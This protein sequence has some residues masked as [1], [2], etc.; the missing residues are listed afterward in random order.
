MSKTLAPCWRFLSCSVC[1]PIL[2]FWNMFALCFPVFSTFDHAFSECL[3]MS[4]AGILKYK[5]LPESVFA[6]VL[7]WFL[8]FVLVPTSWLSLFCSWLID[9]HFFPHCLR[10]PISGW[11]LSKPQS[12]ADLTV[13]NSMFLLLSSGHQQLDQEFSHLLQ[14]P[15][16]HQIVLLS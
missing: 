16:S 13:L 1:Q 2:P 11:H 7:S 8:Q 6:C 3:W 5:L 15:F 12:I 4:L 14:L 10:K 9:Q